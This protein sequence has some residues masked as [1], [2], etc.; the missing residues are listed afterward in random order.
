MPTGSPHPH[1]GSDQSSP[2]WAPG[3]NVWPDTRGE[4]R[5]SLESLPMPISGNV[6]ELASGLPHLGLGLPGP[7]APLP[8]SHPPWAITGDLLPPG[9]R[10]LTLQAYREPTGF[11]QVLWGAQRDQNRHDP[12]RFP[13]RVW[14][15]SPRECK[16]HRKF[17]RPPPACTTRLWVN[18]ALLTVKS[19]R[20]SVWEGLR[21]RLLST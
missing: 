15:P 9:G 13:G 21:Q 18:E 17:P 11:G 8:P 10:I 19:K 7:S 4:L 5:Y 3:T 16:K 2:Q 12:L 14:D 20:P 6:A 1:W